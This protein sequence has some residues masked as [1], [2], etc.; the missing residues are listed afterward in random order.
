MLLLLKI[1]T[2]LDVLSTRLRELS[3]LNAGVR[4]LIH[5]VRS[6]K[7]HDFC[8]EGGLNS[9]VEHLNKKRNPLH[10]D[11]IYLTGEREFDDHGRTVN[12]AA[13]I[14]VMV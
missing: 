10:P 4:I 1:M 2:L 5:D 13:L 9:F 8:Y 12:V 14:L 3:F 11:P 6:D 7:K